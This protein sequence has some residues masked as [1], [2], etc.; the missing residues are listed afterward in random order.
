MSGVRFRGLPWSPAR[1][2]ACCA[3][4]C[5]RIFLIAYV[6]VILS[7][8]CVKSVLGTGQVMMDSLSG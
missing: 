4:L 3:S 8:F 7:Q 2:S 5:L 6:A 1:R